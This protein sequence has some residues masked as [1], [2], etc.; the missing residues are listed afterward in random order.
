MV[1][2]FFAGSRFNK[3]FLHGGP[4]TLFGQSYTGIAHGDHVLFLNQNKLGIFAQDLIN[5]ICA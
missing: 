2:M 3:D 1:A 4:Q 5:I